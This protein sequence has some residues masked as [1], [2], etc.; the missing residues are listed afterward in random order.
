MLKMLIEKK[1]FREIDGDSF[2][3]SMRIDLKDGLNFHN[4]EPD[5]H[6]KCKGNLRTNFEEW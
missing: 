5:C 2:I 1:V 3:Y 4:Q 6:M